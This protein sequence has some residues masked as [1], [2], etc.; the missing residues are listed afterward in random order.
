MSSGLELTLMKNLVQDASGIRDV[1][2]AT[3]L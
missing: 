3:Y 2:Q 1:L